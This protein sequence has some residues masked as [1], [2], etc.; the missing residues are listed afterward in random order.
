VQTQYKHTV[1]GHGSEPNIE[2]RK[3]APYA[4]TS[5]SQQSKRHHI[6]MRLGISHC[7]R[8]IPQIL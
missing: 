7:V 6:K 8:N 2:N 5:R 1:Y 4:I 3:H